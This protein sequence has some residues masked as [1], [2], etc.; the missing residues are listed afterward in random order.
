MLD[1]DPVDLAEVAVCGYV[2][3]RDGAQVVEIDTTEGT[4]RVRVVINDGTIYDGDPMTD[5]P[6]GEHYGGPGWSS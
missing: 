4:G 6:P 1:A 5:E 3:D 2:S